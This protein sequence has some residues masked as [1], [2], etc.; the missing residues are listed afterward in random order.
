MVSEYFSIH[1]CSVRYL[2]FTSNTL[3]LMRIEAVLTTVA[4]SDIERS[5]A[6]SWLVEVQFA[7]KLAYWMEIVKN[8]ENPF[9]ILE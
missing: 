3:G 9:E 2:V 1:D 4:I 5:N 8:D 6:H 7:S